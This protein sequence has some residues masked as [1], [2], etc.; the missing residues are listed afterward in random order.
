M[1][2]IETIMDKSKLFGIILI[3]IAI[4]LVV[5]L[6]S[7]VGILVFKLLLYF[8][9]AVLVGLLVYSWLHSK[10]KRKL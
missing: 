1:N 10:V 7:V 6:I 3:S 8:I 5:L 9:P 4:A 2:F